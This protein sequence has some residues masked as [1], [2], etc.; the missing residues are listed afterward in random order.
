M[1]AAQGNRDS[2]VT[3]DEWVKYYEEV[4]ASIDSDDYFG[5]MLAGTW[6]HLKKRSQAGGKAEPVVKFVAKADIER[7]EKLLRSYIYAKVPND[8]NTKRQ[9][10]RAFSDFDTDGSG[11]VS[12]GEFVKALER[13]GMHT[14]GQRPGVGGLPMDVVQSL[15]DKYD[16]D[17]SGSIDY[18]EF[19]VALFA[20][21][22]PPPPPPPPPGGKAAKGEGCAETAYL[23]QSNHIF[24]AIARGEAPNPGQP[25][26]YK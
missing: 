21:D 8:Q 24:G 16:K 14:T 11:A 4:S 7:L 22:E 2:K 25:G 12:M 1:R 3:L 9:V 18:K 10:Q 5:T 15:F 13:F 20:P 26:G 6:A 23:K 17:G 19:C